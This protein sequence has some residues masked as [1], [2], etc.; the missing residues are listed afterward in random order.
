MRGLSDKYVFS[1]NGIVAFTHLMYTLYALDLED[2]YKAY[3]D[4]LGSREDD[5][6]TLTVI[7]VEEPV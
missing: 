6:W 2:A 7:Y 4:P 3:S 1:G 5:C